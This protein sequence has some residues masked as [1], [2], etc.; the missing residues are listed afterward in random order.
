MTDK[1]EYLQIRITP[2]MK[3]KL[4]RLAH[5]DGRS[6]AGYIRHLIQ[7]AIEQRG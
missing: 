1:T 4:E 7:K 2:E 5:K 6:A 3:D